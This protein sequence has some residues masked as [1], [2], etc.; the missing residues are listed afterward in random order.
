MSK[1]YNTLVFISTYEYV[2]HLMVYLKFYF[3]YFTSIIYV[4]ASLY[5]FIF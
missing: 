5:L 2:Y 3:M 1:E 4:C